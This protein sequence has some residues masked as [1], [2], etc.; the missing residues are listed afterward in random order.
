MNDLKRVNEFLLTE[1]FEH[2]RMKDEIS[3]IE[4][5]HKL[6]VPKSEIISETLEAPKTELEKDRE[7]LLLRSQAALE[8]LQKNLDGL[9]HNF[10]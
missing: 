5:K 1:S 6:G 2:K 10:D 9:K 3:R 7:S 8:K 4:R